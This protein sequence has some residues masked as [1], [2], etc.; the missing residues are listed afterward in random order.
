VEDA[1]SCAI[2]V[3]MGIGSFQRKKPTKSKGNDIRNLDEFIDLNLDI[4][5]DEWRR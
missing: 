2:K 1:I 3:G 4:R 5:R